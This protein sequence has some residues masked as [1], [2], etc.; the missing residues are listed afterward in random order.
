MA[1]KITIGFDLQEI[2]LPLERIVPQKSIT[3]KIRQSR[4]Y[5]QIAASMKAVGIIEPLAVF[6]IPDQEGYYRLLSGHVRLDIL[7]N[8]GATETACIISKDDEAFTYNHKVNRLSAIQEHFMV[9]KAVEKGLTE[10]ELAEA[11]NVNVASIRL[12]RNLLH[13][14]CDD[15][16]AR[17]KDYP[18]SQPAIRVISRMHPARQIV[19]VGQMI[20]MNSFTHKFALQLL[21]TT[22]QN[23]LVNPKP[24]YMESIS[25]ETIAQMD[26]ELAQSRA[27]QENIREQLGIVNVQLTRLSTYGEKL[28][29]NRLINQYLQ[30]RHPQELTD[31]QQLLGMYR[32]AKQKKAA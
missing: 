10:E 29:R 8:T 4:K 32:S 27:Q 30:K 19:V 5:R 23:L 31:M 2:I 17:I 20:A 14:I 9:L 24:K 11:L 18:F 1:K 6:P 21:A 22:P 13:G 3:E 25:A 12:K 26:M 16:V 7:R 28:L 15:A